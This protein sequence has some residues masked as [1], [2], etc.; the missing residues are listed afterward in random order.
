M[1]VAIRQTLSRPVP[2]QVAGTIEA[3]VGADIA[4]VFDF[5]P[6]RRISVYPSGP[7]SETLHESRHEP[8]TTA[9]PLSTLR[10]FY[11]RRNNPVG[12]TDTRGSLTFP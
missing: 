8:G 12:R 7:A 4:M 10:G 3:H 11:V 5:V 2:L 1:A 6:D 9:L